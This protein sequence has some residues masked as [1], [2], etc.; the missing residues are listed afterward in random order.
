[1]SNDRAASFAV[2]LDHG[3]GATLC[4]HRSGNRLG[5]RNFTWSMRVQ[6]NIV[7]LRWGARQ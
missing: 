7:E 3:Q 4:T 6:A 1:M 5:E 2:E